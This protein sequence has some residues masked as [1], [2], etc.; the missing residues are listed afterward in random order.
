GLAVVN[1]GNNGYVSQ[2]FITHIDYSSQ[3]GKIRSH[4]IILYPFQNAIATFFS[5]KHIK[6]V[7]K[8]IPS[9]RESMMQIGEDTLPSTTNA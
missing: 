9:S 2:F 4:K 3:K 1:V 8:S 7:C 6:K 5:A